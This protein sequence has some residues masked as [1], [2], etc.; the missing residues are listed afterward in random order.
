MAV[1]VQDIAGPEQA[2]QGAGDRRVGEEASEIGDSLYEIVAGIAVALDQGVE[3][4]FERRV[5]VGR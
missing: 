3:L 5:I 1:A 4:G 2:L